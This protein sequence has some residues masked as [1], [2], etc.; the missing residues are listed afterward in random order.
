M[1]NSGGAMPPALSRKLR[2][3]CPQARLYLMY[4]LTEAFR[5][6]YLDPALVEARPESVGTAIP[7]A[8]VLVVRPDGSLADAGEP[9]EIVHCG[10]LVAQG[11][12]QDAERTALRFRPAPSA[13]HY[14]GIAVWS[15]DY[16]VQ[17]ADGLI[18]FAGPADEMIKTAG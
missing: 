7:H 5:S 1:T 12:W 18:T 17:G 3:L 11:Y 9:G 15:G 10:P 4:G 14:G 2:A 16:G 6:T 13:S 8:E